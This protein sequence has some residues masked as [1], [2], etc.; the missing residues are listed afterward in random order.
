MFADIAPRYDLLNHFCPSISDRGWRKALLKR[1]A[2]VLEQARGPHSRSMLRNR[3]CVVGSCKPQPRTVIGVDFCHPMLV[4]AQQKARDRGFH[5]PLIEADAMQLA[6]AGRFAGRHFNRFRLSQLDQLWRCTH[7]VSARAETRR[8]TGDLGVLASTRAIYAHGLRLLFG[9]ILP[10][11]GALISGSREAY[12]YLPESVSKFPKAEA[13]SGMMTR[14]VS[15]MCA[16]N[17]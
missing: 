9:V 14:P 7:R 5:A 11:V 1:L 12:T 3:R 17:Y 8:N 15:A 16:T 10:A 4:T 2:P 6:F 13:L